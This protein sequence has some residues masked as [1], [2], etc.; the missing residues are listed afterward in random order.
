MASMDGPRSMIEDPDF[1]KNS[2][3]WKKKIDGPSAKSSA[4]T[5]D[6][7]QS[8]SG[9]FSAKIFNS[10]PMSSSWVQS[11]QV[12]PAHVY[13][14]SGWMKSENVRA[15]PQTPSLGGAQVG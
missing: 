12:A 2:N 6:T 1:E 13:E 4:L 3:S 5:F 14:I 11:I 7:H 15:D 8:H 10:S 9:S